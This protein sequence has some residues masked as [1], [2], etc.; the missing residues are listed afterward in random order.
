M[1]LRYLVWLA[2]KAHLCFKGI[3]MS[4]QI[5]PSIDKDPA[6]KDISQASIPGHP[7]TGYRPLHPGESNS[8]I[9]AAA[10]EIL[11][12]SQLGDQVPFTVDGKQYM[13]R[14]EPHYHQPPPPGED[15]SRY[16]KPWDWHRGVTVFKAVTTDTLSPSENYQ[17]AKPTSGRLQLLQ[18]LDQ[19]L[20]EFGG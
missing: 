4:F 17:P 7:P 10:Q 18:R 3:E 11:R 12:N 5:Q 2:T 13:G 15:P 1:T 19:L 9:G 8:E 16:P 20:D 14:S 6:I